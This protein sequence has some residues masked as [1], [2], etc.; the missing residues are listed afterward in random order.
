MRRKL[1]YLLF[2]VLLSGPVYSQLGGTH[3]YSI[4]NLRNSAKTAALGV[5]VL[6]CF[7]DD[8]SAV[9]TNPS[10]ISTENHNDFALTYTALFDGISQAGL[11]YS[12]S[13][14]AFGNLGA[15]LQYLN[16]GDFEMTE[17]NGDVVGRF[18]AN[19]YAFTLAWSKMLDSNVYIG[20]SLKPIYSQYETYSSFALAIDL[21][22]SY[23]SNN[24]SWAASVIARN[25]G[26]QIST[27]ATQEES[28]PFDLQLALYKKLK[29]APLSIYA[30]I[31]NLHKWNIREDDELNPRDEV[32][33]NGEV[34]KENKFVG[35]MDNA[36][37]HLQFGV[38][39]TPSK[40]FY[41]ALG[42]SWKQNREMQI[43]DTFSLA[44][45]SYGVGLNYK[46]FRLAYSRNEYHRYGSPN[47]ITF[48][49]RL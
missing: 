3:A 40:Y 5:D 26:K 43:D 33:L 45:L 21:A 6:S 18:T 35:I 37:R 27:F 49:V 13:L 42:Y 23:Q 20:A 41:L 36:L 32:D 19:E 28:L 10:I 15:G 1:F 9:M 12:Y 14:G 8:V 47:F 22:V 24:R 31:T 38:E 44:G 39:F 34:R 29:H 4:L 25:I 48:L 11:A 46:Q 30:S 2:I 7:T 16:Y 17:E